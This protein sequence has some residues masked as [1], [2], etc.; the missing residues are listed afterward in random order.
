MTVDV[1]KRYFS[2][3]H[4][5]SK[6]FIDLRNFSE[7]SINILRSSQ[8]SVQVLQRPRSIFFYVI[9]KGTSLLGLHAIQRLGIQIDGASLTCT[10]APL[11]PVQCSVGVPPGIITV[12][13]ES[14]L[15]M[16]RASWG[17]IRTARRLKRGADMKI[18]VYLRGCDVA[19]CPEKSELLVM[20]GGRKARPLLGTS[21]PELTR[22]GVRIP[23]ASTLRVLRLTL[24]KG[25]ASMPMIN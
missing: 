18:F 23:M 25:D 7:Q 1:F 15:L 21:D 6:S 3:Q 5:L 4:A 10:L 19:C 9:D 2:N 12:H 8:A 16:S 17:S 20:R 22:N 14:D 13:V 11:P 24:Q